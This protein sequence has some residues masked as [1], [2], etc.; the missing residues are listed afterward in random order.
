LAAL[1]LTV[2]ACSSSGSSANSS[3]STAASSG[4]S[5]GSSSTDSADPFATPNKATGST[6]K[7]G[8][9]SDGK[10]DALDVTE[11]DK[12]AKAA[13]QYANEYLG[14][15]NGHVLDM[16]YCSTVNTPTGATTCG[17]QM[18]NDKV[19]AVLVP[20]SGQDGAVFNALGTSGIPFVSFTSANPD[21]LA[22][23]GAFVFE[24]PVGSIA[25][26]VPIAKAKNP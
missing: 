14:G 21:I 17:V 12:A 22:K 11:A 13:L 15:L 18:V 26:L 7:I 2:T 6:I 19:A 16:D 5:T 1:A 24:N 23:P 20:V 25:A 8:Y 3:S 4:A 10:S 9:V